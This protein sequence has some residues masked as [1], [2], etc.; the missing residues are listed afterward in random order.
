M[1]N[2]LNRQPKTTRRCKKVRGPQ[3]TER[4]KDQ[5]EEKEKIRKALLT[6]GFYK[7]LYQNRTNVTLKVQL[8]P[9]I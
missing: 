2:L 4:G 9:S 3:K 8:Y 7:V 5:E 6:Q 1:P